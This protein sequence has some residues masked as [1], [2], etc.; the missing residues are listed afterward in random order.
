MNIIK[1]NS[2]WYGSVDLRCFSLFA[3]SLGIKER[4]FIGCK[5]VTCWTIEGKKSRELYDLMKHL[6][7]LFYAEFHYFLIFSTVFKMK[8]LC[9]TLLIFVV[10]LTSTNATQ[11]WWQTMSLYQ[12]YP[13]SFKDSNGDGI[14]DLRGKQ[15]KYK[16][17]NYFTALYKIYFIIFIHSVL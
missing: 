15:N 1:N 10:V 8:F 5:T 17:I 7:N 14:G 12:I 16:S 4:N 3:I 2:Q 13:R 6:L 11:K 9:F